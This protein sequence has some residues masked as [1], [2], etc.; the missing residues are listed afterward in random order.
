MNDLFSPTRLASLVLWL[1]SRFLVFPLHFQSQDLHKIQ[2][3]EGYLLPSA[4]MLF[5]L[6]VLFLVV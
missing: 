3:L 2:I 1:G 6:F 4:V 5:R